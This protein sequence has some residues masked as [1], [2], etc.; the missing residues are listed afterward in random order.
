LLNSV[1]ANSESQAERC[2]EGTAGGRTIQSSTISARSSFVSENASVAALSFWD[3]S[4]RTILSKI[5]T[6]R[7]MR[8]N[9]LNTI[10]NKMWCPS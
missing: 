10:Y 5:A 6:L 4:P 2:S 3:E 9:P 8:Q 1:I 7:T